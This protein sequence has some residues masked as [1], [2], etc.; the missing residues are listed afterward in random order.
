[1]STLINILS[2]SDMIFFFFGE[3]SPTVKDATQHLLFHLPHSI[4]CC[5][6]CHTHLSSVT[7]QL[8]CWWNNLKL[9]YKVASPV[10]CLLLPHCPGYL[11][12]TLFC[13][14]SVLV[15]PHHPSYML[16]TIYCPSSM[17]VSST[18]FHFCAC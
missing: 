1:M 4:S 10:L 12:I 8:S 14:S 3:W 6:I 18:L 15:I 13:S 5:F 9:S 17:L 11:L 2:S 16:I 7:G